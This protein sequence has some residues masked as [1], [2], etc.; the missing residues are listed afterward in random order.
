MDE[1]RKAMFYGW[2]SKTKRTDG[3]SPSDILKEMVYSEGRMED[4]TPITPLE[5]ILMMYIQKASK[6][7]LRAADKLLGVIERDWNAQPQQALPNQQQASLTYAPAI[8]MI[9][10][11][12]GLPTPAPVSREQE[13]Q[14]FL[15]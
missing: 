12:A 10:Q 4:G 6:G 1:F 15:Q 5:D 11:Q 2:L 7:S 13:L 9:L 3:K 8:N 14:R